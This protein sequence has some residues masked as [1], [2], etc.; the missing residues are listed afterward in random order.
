MRGVVSSGM[1]LALEQVGYRDGF[2]LVVGTSAGALAATFFV[3]KRAT[4][5][6]VLFYTELNNAP[7]LDKRNAL[8]RRKAIDLDYLVDRASPERGLDYDL[9]RGS[10]IELWATVAA[11]DL[12]NPTKR[13]QMVGDDDRMS[14]ILKASAALPVLG[15]A[16]RM[17]DGE[18]YVDGGLSEQIP[19]RSA[20]ELDATHVLVLPSRPV[21]EVEEASKM[22]FIE[23]FATTK[24]VSSMHGP[25]VA[26]LV[27]RLPDSATNQALSLLAIAD[28]SASAFLSDGRPWSGQLELVNIPDIVRIPSR[29]ETKR[30]VLL[31]GLVGG[32]RTM[33]EHF[34]FDDS[35]SVEQ[36]V[37][38][39]HPDVQVQEFRSEQLTQFVARD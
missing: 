19:W 24:I 20:M 37:V 13:L 5:G 12:D 8:K 29:L 7:F 17:V 23:K 18:A 3:V 36:R 31:D 33:L 9:I 2:D 6:S 28:G 27:G 30:V 21:S 10:E 35:I 38:L 32:A 16:S 1:L 11:T 14:A 26:E 25:R 39:H 22:T 4:E 15:G 34:G